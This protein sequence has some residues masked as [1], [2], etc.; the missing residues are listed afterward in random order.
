MTQLSLRADDIGLPSLSPQ[1]FA[2]SKIRIMSVDTDAMEPTL[3]RGDCVVVLPVT[4]HDQDGVYVVEPRP[5]V[6]TVVRTTY[7]FGGQLRIIRDNHLYSEQLVDAD[8]FNERVVGLVVADIK[9]REAN[10]LRR[11]A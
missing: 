10:V 2:S 4:E 3:S 8:W 7:C 11:L 9:V 5:G 6:I 1:T